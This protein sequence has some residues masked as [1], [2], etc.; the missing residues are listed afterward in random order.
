MLIADCLLLFLAENHCNASMIAQTHG[1][2]AGNFAHQTLLF[3]GSCCPA[4]PAMFCQQAFWLRSHPLPCKPCH[5][6]DLAPAVGKGA[7]SF[8]W[9][10]C[11]HRSRKRQHPK[12][13][14]LLNM[15]VRYRGWPTGAIISRFAKGPSGK[16]PFI[17]FR[18]TTTAAI[19][20][21][22]TTGNTP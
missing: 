18:T 9:L 13:N 22:T 20:T 17:P 16:S 6:L 19:A 12:N 8:L 4:Y 2:T 14:R 10:M 1:D 11:T 5:R 21:T 3:V 7:A 15:M